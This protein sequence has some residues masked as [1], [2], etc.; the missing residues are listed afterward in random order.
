VAADQWA[1]LARSLAGAET[2]WLI[3]VEGE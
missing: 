2:V 1:N 3:H